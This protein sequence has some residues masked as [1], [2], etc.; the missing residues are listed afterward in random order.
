MLKANN[1][2]DFTVENSLTLA[3]SLSLKTLQ[4]V[5]RK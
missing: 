1:N 3:F 4:I 5:R 2:G